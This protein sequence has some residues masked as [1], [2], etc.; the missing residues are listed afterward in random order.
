M[1]GLQILRVR[2]PALGRVVVVVIMPLFRLALTLITSGPLPFY[3]D[4]MNVW[5][6]AMFLCML[7]RPLVVTLN[8]HA[9]VQ[10]LYVCRR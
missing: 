2:K 4:L 3:V 6:S 9:L 1:L 8:R 10:P 7:S 5:L